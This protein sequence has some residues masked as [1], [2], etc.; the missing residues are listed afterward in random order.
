MKNLEE[1]VAFLTGSAKRVGAV[2]AKILHK[3]G[4]NIVVHYRSSSDDAEA[5]K[6]EL[7]LLRPR[8]CEIIQ[9]ELLEV[10]QCQ[11]V[12]ERSSRFFRRLDV[13]INNASTFYPTKIGEVREKHWD[14]LIGVNLKA[15]F[16]LS[17]S[18]VPFLKENQGSII[19]MVDIYADRPLKGFAIYNIAKAGLTMLTKT[20]ARELGPDIR[21]NGIA[22]GVILW[23]DEGTKES[24]QKKI[25][26]RT[27]LKREGDPED[28]AKAMLYLIRDADYM[29]GQILTVD[30]GRTLS[31]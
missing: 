29:T 18:A 14:D 12:I 3:Q 9:G 16:F 20:M 8:S 10:Q 25:I 7:N 5:L 24:S 2:V 21:V 22:P 15:P 13:L 28:I 31:P 11:E 6:A 23:P 4:M 27:A 1:N 19:N 30:G 17:Q 26:A